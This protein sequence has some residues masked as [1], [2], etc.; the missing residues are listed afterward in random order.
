MKTYNQ[1]V[2]IFVNMLTLFLGRHQNLRILSRIYM[3]MDMSSRLI[4]FLYIRD[5]NRLCIAL[6]YSDRHSLKKIA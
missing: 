3:F 6:Q 4:F 1:C 2:M 5:K